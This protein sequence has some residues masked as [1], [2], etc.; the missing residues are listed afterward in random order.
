MNSYK[1]QMFYE[2]KDTNR[3]D[4]PEIASLFGTSDLFF[5]TFAEPVKG[6]HQA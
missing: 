4:D 1:L 5:P 3:T 2:M 6:I